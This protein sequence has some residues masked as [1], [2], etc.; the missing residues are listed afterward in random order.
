MNTLARIAGLA[1]GLVLFAPLWLAP[2]AIGIA[3]DEG[4]VQQPEYVVVDRTD[5]AGSFSWHWTGQDGLGQPTA[6]D[7]IAL[8]FRVE[9]PAGES[10]A[11]V[12]VLIGSV[13]VG[14][15]T[16]MFSEVL[17]TVPPG[18]YRAAV[19]LRGANGLW[20]PF[21]S[22]LFLDVREGIGPPPEPP[23]PSAPAA[24]TAFRVDRREAAP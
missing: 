2:L 21:S 10:A 1:L 4:P 9:P 19:Q 20:S 12:V 11:V 17:A 14:T 6:A 24:P 18:K 8:K 15:T 3:L 13:G 16:H 7:R 5:P 22:D 23:V